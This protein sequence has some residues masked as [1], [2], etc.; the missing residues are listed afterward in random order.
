MTCTSPCMR[1]KIRG[2]S[3]QM[4]LIDVVVSGTL[5]G[6]KSC[7]QRDRMVGGGCCGGSAEMRGIKR[8]HAVLSSRTR[9][10]QRTWSTQVTEVQ[11][12]VPISHI[13][14]VSEHELC[15]GLGAKIVLE[16]VY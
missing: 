16:G 14:R 7:S 3:R 9:S 15:Y 6:H 10:M 13:W 4:I 8:L 1:R 2:V 12:R 5:Q 11:L